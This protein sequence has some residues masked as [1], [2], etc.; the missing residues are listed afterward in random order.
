MPLKEERRLIHLPQ[1]SSCST[2]LVL[3]Q[4]GAFL[5]Q[6][7]DTG[8]W[9]AAASKSKHFKFPMDF[10]KC[11]GFFVWVLSLPVR[12]VSVG[13]SLT[14]CD[15][16]TIQH[17]PESAVQADLSCVHNI[18]QVNMPRVSKA[19]GDHA[20]STLARLQAEDQASYG[21]WNSSSQLLSRKGFSGVG[22]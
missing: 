17:Y 12:R 22:S 14:F 18:L 16:G 4:F 2:L 13:H 6:E 19:S 15:N 3:C 9:K 20:S 8:A 1:T 5:P 10:A 21:L 11:T 7:A